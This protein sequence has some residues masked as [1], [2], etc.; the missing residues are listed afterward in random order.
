MKLHSCFLSIIVP[1]YNM[2]KYLP[3]CLDSLLAQDILADDYEII[4]IHDGSTDSSA[5][6][7]NK[8]GREHANIRVIHKEN[9]GVSSARNLGIE[10]ARGDYLWFVDSDDF[11]APNC[12]GKLRMLAEQYH[13]QMIRFNYQSVTENQSYSQTA[14]EGMDGSVEVYSAGHAEICA[15]YCWISLINRELVCE[16]HI[17]F[18]YGMKYCEDVTFYMQAVVSLSKDFVVF[19]KNIYYY[20]QVATS[21]IHKVDPASLAKKAEDFLYKIHVFNKLKK[22]ATDSV[23]KFLTQHNLETARILLALLPQTQLSISPIL[24]QLKKEG[25]FPLP[26]DWNRIRSQKSMRSK[27]ILLRNSMMFKSK[28]LYLSYLCWKR[29]RTSKNN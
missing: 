13:P 12:L 27:I 1:V 28:L 16:N 3:E 15:D 14:F 17:L 21:A 11:V 23:Q 6:I 5:E 19:P 22:Q 29:S 2:Q 24:S 8:Y 9:G 26:I 7:L 4:C 10:N 20:R 25:V 18:D